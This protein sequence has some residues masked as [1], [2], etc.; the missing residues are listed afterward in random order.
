MITTI[1]KE[2]LEPHPDNPRK[3]LRDLG[4]LIGS[5]RRQG[6]LQNLTVVPHP[7]KEGMYRIVIGHRRYAA[8][9]AAGLKELPCVISDMSYEEQLAVM[10]SENMQR[11]DLTVTERVGGVQL[12]MDL[13]MTPAKIAMDTGISDSSVRRYAKLASLDRAQMRKAEQRGATLMQL[14]EISAIED[15]QIRQ[16][17]LEKVGTGE[18]G[19]VMHSA[20]LDA[21]R[22]RVLPKVLEIVEEYARPIDGAGMDYDRYSYET[23]IWIDQPDAIAQARK[24]RPA[25]AGKEQFVFAAQG[26]SVT[27]YKLR[28]KAAEDQAAR[29]R[30]T[31]L[32][33]IRARVAREQEVARAFAD[34]RADWL[35]GASVRRRE[36]EAMRFVLWAFSRAEY[37]NSLRIGGLFAYCFVPQSE[38]EATGAGSLV[39]RG[40]RI[41]AMPAGEMLYALVVAAFDRISQGEMTLLDRYT[42]KPKEDA[43]VRDL[44]RFLEPVGYEPCAEERAWL[45]GTHECFAQEDEKSAR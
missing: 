29:K 1:S 34:M 13:G 38:R 2:R 24:A 32:E 8:A 37:L 11:N 43:L 27:L 22:R 3:E 15:E 36:N 12:M 25:D 4:D 42:G 45:A 30:R 20:R 28:N 41:E 17:A 14:A 33:R 44:Y 5:V 9:A 21:A 35:K 23:T 39:L 7:D 26:A 18:Y 10:M 19:R 16:Q 31:E 6:I 40:G